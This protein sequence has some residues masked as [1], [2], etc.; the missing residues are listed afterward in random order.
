MRPTLAEATGNR[1]R[2][3][4]NGVVNLAVPCCYAATTTAPRFGVSRLV[5]V[6]LIIGGIVAATHH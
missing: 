6:Y 4:T 3:L 2:W 1:P 5:A